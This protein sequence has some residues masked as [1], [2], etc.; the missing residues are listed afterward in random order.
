MSATSSNDAVP[1]AVGGPGLLHVDPEGA[2]LVFRRLLRHPIED[3]WEAITD[4][5]QLE[6]WY[7][8]KVSRDSAHGIVEFQHPNELRA[9]GR[10]LEWTPP[11]IY[12]YEWNVAP[13][14]GIPQGENSVVRWELSAVEDGTL[15]VMT[16]RKLSRR[17]AETF[18]RGFND[19]LDRLCAHLDGAPLP[20]PPWLSRAHRND[21][22][23]G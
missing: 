13:G 21:R 9:R 23:V 19:F 12:E 2:S 18:V 7:M 3:V 8:A 14:S 1:G 16:H 15:L 17:S 4:P 10:L 22:K 11:R 5:E 6:L 20:E